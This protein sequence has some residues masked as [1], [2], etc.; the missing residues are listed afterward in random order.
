MVIRQEKP[1]KWFGFD[2]NDCVIGYNEESLKVYQDNKVEHIQVDMN[3]VATQELDIHK[4]ICDDF[5]RLKK[6]QNNY[7]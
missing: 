6:Q 5:R 3:Y 4:K 1:W 7:G 2:D